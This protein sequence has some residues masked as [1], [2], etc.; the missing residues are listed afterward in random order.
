MRRGSRRVALYPYT[1]TVQVDAAPKPVAKAQV[2]SLYYA[3]WRDAPFDLHTDGARAYRPGQTP[4]PEEE[5]ALRM[6]TYVDHTA[7]EYAVLDED[8]V[9]LDNME[10]DVGHGITSAMRGTQAI[11]RCWRSIKRYV[12][13][14][15][16]SS[17]V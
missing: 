11:D 9:G 2:I 17:G 3:H 1:E 7:D 13:A 12:P 15:V 6:H 10:G 14:S 5:E 4:L 8:D 16:T